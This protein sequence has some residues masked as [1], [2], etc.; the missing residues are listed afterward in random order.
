ME[1]RIIDTLKRLMAQAK[2]TGHRAIQFRLSKEHWAQAVADADGDGS[3][4]M[5]DPAASLPRAFMGVPVEL[6]ELAG[7]AT[8]EMV[9]EDGTT[10][11]A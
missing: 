3:T 2:A 6:R 8:V 5:A 1:E 9:Y 11:D 7:N 4:I 10:T